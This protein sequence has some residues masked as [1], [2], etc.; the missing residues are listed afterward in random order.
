M[1]AVALV[2]A[3]ALPDRALTVTLMGGGGLAIPQMCDRIRG[4]RLFKLVDPRGAPDSADRLS[5]PVE[6]I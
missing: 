5:Y 4:R 2:G 6:G 3:A 1:L